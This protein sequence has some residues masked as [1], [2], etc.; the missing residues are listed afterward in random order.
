MSSP[1]IDPVRLEQNWRA[2]NAEIDAPV[3][4]RLERVIRRLGFPAAMTRVALA[5]PSLR[6]SWLVAVAVVAFLGLAAGD[7]TDGGGVFG[8]LA[9]APLVPVL[10]V[11]LAYGVDADPTYEIALATPT[12]GLRLVLMRA[13]VTVVVSTLLVVP[14]SL[15][16]PAV[17]VRAVAW[18]LPA[19]A[20]TT[21]T[22][23]VSTW[24]W[25]RRAAAI[26]G[27][28]WLGLVLLLRGATADGLAAFSLPAQA[29]A[30]TLAV[31]AGGLLWI[32]RDRF[33][34]LVVRR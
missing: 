3:P 9:I 1:T 31:V 28:G 4:T 12:R 18:L 32:R 21:I 24:V 19:I 33:D 20:L 2:I 25:P 5:T 27:V 15:L 7:A 14:V 34:E 10:G 8:F 26:V 16:N 22:L 17:G 6:R 23:V 11:A 13:A 30:L 29:V